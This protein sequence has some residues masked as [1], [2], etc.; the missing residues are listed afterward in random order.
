MQSLTEHEYECLNRD[1]WGRAPPY[2]CSETGPMIEGVTGYTV[3]I[4]SNL[5]REVFPKSQENLLFNSGPEKH[6]NSF[7][8]DK[9]QRENDY[10]C[11]FTTTN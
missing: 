4:C 9:K 10:A 7:K 8:A 1:W 5:V 3:P 2:A 11:R 6:I